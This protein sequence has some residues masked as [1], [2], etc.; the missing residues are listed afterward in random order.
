MKQNNCLLGKIFCL[1]LCSFF[2][3]SGFDLAVSQA[4]K[5]LITLYEKE[6]KETL[7]L[8]QPFKKWSKVAKLDKQASLQLTG[9]L[10]KIDCA[11]AFYPVA[12]AFVEAT[13]PEGNYALGKQDI[14]TRTTSRLAFNRLINGDIDILFAFAPSDK[15]LEYA[16]QKGVELKLQPIG[17]EAFVFFVNE[18]NPVHNL[19][20]EQ[21]QVI[22]SG[23]ITN[24]QQV[25][26]L[27]MPIKAFQRPKNSG[28]QT[29]LERLM[30]GKKILPAPIDMVPYSMMAIFDRV[31]EFD[32]SKNAIGYSFRF[33][34]TEMM[35]MPVR[36]LSID[37]VEPTEENIANGKYPL[38]EE[39]YLITTANKNP[40]VEAFI[41]WILSTEGQ[42]LV[43]KIGYSKIEP[44]VFIC[45]RPIASR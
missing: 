11:T 44:D 12:A 3:L 30:A 13:Y 38:T 24:W 18:F 9:R 21:V 28:S 41:S 2:L 5:P 35:T 33:Y 14:L 25:G 29:A 36:L 16:A 42:E 7:T 45:I 34:A 37:G 4:Q 22:Y 1:F 39:F 27:D 32:D 8:Y 26:G 17:K 19:T 40:N 23:E 20:I 6:N 15:Q 43:E 31:A 10:P